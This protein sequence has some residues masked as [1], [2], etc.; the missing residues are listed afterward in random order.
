MF[1]ISLAGSQQ[2]SFTNSHWGR[3][4]ADDTNAALHCRWLSNG[5]L[6]TSYGENILL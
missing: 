4:T 6:W 1:N 5:R 3:N 2:G